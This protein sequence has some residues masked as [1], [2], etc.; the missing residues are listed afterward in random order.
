MT[1]VPFVLFGATGDLARKMLIPALFSFEQKH[2]ECELHVTGVAGSSYSN[3]QFRSYVREVLS[4]RA[5]RDPD[6]VE[7]FCAR[8]DYLSGNYHETAVF[9]RLRAVVH[10]KDRP[11]F[12]LA[13]PPTMFEVVVEQLN[14][15][16]YAQ[17]GRVMI[18]KPFGRDLKDAEELSN[19]LNRVFWDDQIYRIDHFLGKEAVQN[20]LVFRFANSI[21][22]PIWNRNYIARIEL[23]ML[24]SF[25]VQG[26]GGFYD[27]V[28][29]IRDVVQ[30][31]LLQL[32][33]L[34][35]MEAPLSMDER[36]I[37]DER[38][39]VLRA[40]APIDPDLAVLAQY[41]GYEK[42]LGVAEGSG[43]PTFV[44]LRMA[45]NSWRWAHVPVFIRAGKAL[46][47]TCTQA[48]VEFRQPPTMIF[49]HQGTTH[50]PHPNRLVFRFKPD[51]RIVLHMQAKAAGS[52]LVSRSVQL[53]VASS[54]ETANSDDAYA[55]LIDDVINEDHSR[56]ATE[57]SVEEAWRI[58]APILDRDAHERYTPGSRG[59]EKADALVDEWRSWCI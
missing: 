19:V 6:R 23:T 31:H 21:L 18:E 5:G 24:E 43:T 1:A 46:D 55:Q 33:C 49:D 4:A 27:S 54:T 11:I 35:L 28:G 8:I 7:E 12:Y 17:H 53:E 58:V 44:A 30:N 13:I 16:G 38:L 45:V 56:F 57:A 50:Q 51:G 9:E 59:P 3:E 36:S 10:P 37:A 42:E 2:P 48:V 29:V 15:A 34:L 47:I 26:R 39:K 52:Q 32:L 40:M 20:L 41:D 25:D 22:E 14:T